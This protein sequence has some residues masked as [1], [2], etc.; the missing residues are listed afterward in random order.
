MGV[1]SGNGQGYEI[2]ARTPAAL[3]NR[4]GLQP[5]DRI[6]SLNGQTVGQGQNEAQLLEQARQD[7]QVRLEVQRGDQVITVQQNFK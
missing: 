5:C 1:N 7:G 2:T 3:R 6:L 4:L